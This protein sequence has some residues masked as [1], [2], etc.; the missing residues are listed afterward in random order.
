MNGL[1]RSISASESC[2]AGTHHIMQVSTALLTLA[3]ENTFHLLLVQI[4]AFDVFGVKFFFQ[5]A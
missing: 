4:M 3:V 2:H 1:A 5:L